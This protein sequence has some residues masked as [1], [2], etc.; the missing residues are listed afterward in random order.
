MSTRSKVI[1]KAPS[2]KTLDYY[3]S[4]SYQVFV[5]PL[6]KEDG[7]GYVAY[8]PLLGKFAFSATGSTIEEALHGLEDVKRSNFQWMLQHDIPIPEPPDEV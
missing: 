6:P 4:L 3:M 1:E 8:I 2:R 5:K 7:G